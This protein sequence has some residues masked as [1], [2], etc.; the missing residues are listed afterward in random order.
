MESD[1]AQV[2]ISERNGASNSPHVVPVW[3]E[4]TTDD[5]AQQASA[6]QLQVGT[7][8]DPL[9]SHEQNVLQRAAV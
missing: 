2:V 3:P 9:S 5:R 6:V 4:R 7:S 8:L 1:R